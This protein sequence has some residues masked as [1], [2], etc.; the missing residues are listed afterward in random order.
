MIQLPVNKEVY[1]SAPFKID[2]SSGV[3][4]RNLSKIIVRAFPAA[5]VT[6]VS[7]AKPRWYS[8]VQGHASSLP[9][10]LF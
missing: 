3:L 2:K 4:E 5:H 8:A 6:V 7:K 1:I 10:F 9:V